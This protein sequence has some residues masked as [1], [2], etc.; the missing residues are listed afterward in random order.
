MMIEGARNFL[1]RNQAVFDDPRSRVVIDD[2]RAHFSRSASRY[3][4]IVS[5]PSNPWVSG[6]SG[7][8]SVEFYQH[9]ASH[10]APD[11]HFLQWLHL[12]EASPEMAASIVRA[13]GTVFPAFRAYQSN[14]GD[15]ILV[16]RNG[17]GTPVLQS[18][19]LDAMPAL[20]QQLARV[21]IGSAAMLE[22]H[23]LGRGN[24]I[25]L[26]ADTY[27]APPNSDFFPYVDQRAAGD[28]FRRERANLL[29]SLRLA[30]VPIL[31][32]TSGAPAHVGRIQAAGPGMPAHVRSLAASTNALRYLKDEPLDEAALALI[33]PNALDYAALKGWVA[34][35][36]FPRDGEPA[37]DAAVR[38]AAAVNGG[39][40][41]AA[42]A[43]WWKSVGQRCGARMTPLQ[44]AWVDLFAAT[45]ARD[46]AAAARHAD[47]VLATDRPLSPEMRSYATLASVA[48]HMVSGRRAE[49]SRVLKQQSALL[50]VQDLDNSW[51]RYLAFA[52]LTREKPQ[53]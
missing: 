10:L 16:A 5:E 29:F 7:L 23:D 18:G 30:P 36:R 35:C 26:L 38:T 25:R 50:S 37:W 21:G 11:G 32:F 48:G 41:A 14:P 17:E 6:V 39:V 42:A 33:A 1:P 28:R 8:F 31:D 40:S 52:L 3:D 4:L 13:F 51:F 46:A 2:A 53:P 45:G 44:R 47:R 34:H 9:I 20:Q 27:P 24:A 49:S 22:A 15:V 12:Y 43:G 19:M